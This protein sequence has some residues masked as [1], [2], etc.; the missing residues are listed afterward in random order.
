MVTG[1]ATAEA[2]R[3]L[4]KAEETEVWTQDRVSVSRAAVTKHCKLGDLKQQKFIVS[5]FWRLH[6]PNP[7]AGR[8]VL[9]LKAPG[10]NPSFQPLVFMGLAWCSLSSSCSTVVSA[11]D[12]TWPLS[13]CQ[14]GSLLIRTSV[15]LDVRS[16]CSYV[17]SS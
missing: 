5:L 3:S 17:T 15:I 9:S 11:S 10:D 16:P 14:S 7:G 8:A 12:V 1:G 2:V 4:S 13:L 6:I